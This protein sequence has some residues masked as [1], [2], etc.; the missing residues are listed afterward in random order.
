M[1]IYFRAYKTTQ[2]SGS[3]NFTAASPDDLNALNENLSD[4]KADQESLRRIHKLVEKKLESLTT[5][6][7]SYALDDLKKSLKSAIWGSEKGNDAGLLKDVESL[8]SSISTDRVN[9]EKA[10]IEMDK[11]IKVT[12]EQSDKLEGRLR[13]VIE[14]GEWVQLFRKEVEVIINDF[15][16]QV[17]SAHDRL[18]GDIEK[19]KKSSAE[20]EILKQAILDTIPKIQRDVG[21]VMKGHGD[22]VCININRKYDEC[23]QKLEEERNT[24]YFT[25]GLLPHLVKAAVNIKWQ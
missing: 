19:I 21:E 18:F 7:D 20:I 25:T 10:Q 24:A 2:W 3:D 5:R 15:N 22:D 13:K 8:R 14:N 4:L 9:A 16:S 23:S 11:K 12:H 1:P 17:K 6:I